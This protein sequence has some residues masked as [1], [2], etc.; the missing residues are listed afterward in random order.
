MSYNLLF[1]VFGAAHSLSWDYLPGIPQGEE[2]ER[3]YGWQEKP[4]GSFLARYILRGRSPAKQTPPTESAI[5]K[6]DV[7]DEET[8]SEVILVESGVEQLDVTDPEVQP[9]RRISRLSTQSSHPHPGPDSLSPPAD[10]ALHPLG[11]ESTTSPPG[12]R[13]VATVKRLLRPL[14]AIVTPVPMTILISLPIALIQP[15]KALFV[16]VSGTGGPDWKGPDGKPPLAFMID[17]GT[18]VVCKILH[19]RL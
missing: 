5:Q 4:I 7:T 3:R 8:N 10:S 1:W 15:L 6:L 9:A 12:H 11:S 13:L 16:D 17:T 14:T 19:A 18:H 2:A